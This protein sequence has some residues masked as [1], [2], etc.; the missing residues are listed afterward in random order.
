MVLPQRIGASILWLL[1]LFLKIIVLF[2]QKLSNV[3]N[4]IVSN[5]R[6]AERGDPGSQRTSPRQIAGL[7]I[8]LSKMR[9]Q[10]LQEQALHRGLPIVGKTR[11]RLIQDIKEYERVNSEMRFLEV[12]PTH[13]YAVWAVPGK[14]TARGVWAGDRTT[15]TL[16][17]R[18]LPYGRYRYADGT[19]LGRYDT[20][21]CAIAV[22]KSEAARHSA[23]A[24]PAII[25]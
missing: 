9:L 14:P 18:S 1:C 5:Q 16:V 19:R 25:H 22:Y 11:P 24:P 15:W 3:M 10:A 17:Q 2:F 20:L 7:P 12:P 6:L 8:G 13:F 21:E 4:V 23:P